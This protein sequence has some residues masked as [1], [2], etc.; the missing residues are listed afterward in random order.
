MLDT[1]GFVLV[2]AGAGS[3]KTRVL[4]YRIAHLINQ[5]VKPW[6][7]LAITFTNKA[8]GEMRHRVQQLTGTDE[9]LMCTFHSLC[10]RILRREAHNLPGYGA[11]FTIY[12]EAESARTVSAILKAMGVDEKG[13]KEQCLSAISAAKSAGIPP[14]QYR[15]YGHT[16]DKIVEVYTRYEAVLKASNAFD[17]DDLLLKTLQLLKGNKEVLEKYRQRYKYVHVDE[18]QDTN[19]VQY[20]IARLLSGGSGN[21]FVVGDDDQCIYTWR[22][23]D[24][25]GL[26]NFKKK[27]PDTKIYK[28]EQNFRSTQPI[29]KAANSVISNNFVRMGKELFTA[30][31][32]G[33]AVVFRQCADDRAEADYILNEI[34]SLAR[35]GNRPLSDF[36]ILVRV[37]SV[38]RILE[39]R[40]NLYSIP[41]RLFGGFRFY[42]RKEI[43]DILAYLRLAVNQQ[44]KDALLRIINFPR[45]G[46][47]ESS[48]EKLEEFAYMR[49]L[50]LFE[51]LFEIEEAAEIPN[52]ARQKFIAFR[53]F[54]MTLVKESKVRPLGDFVKYLIEAA[55]F[56]SAFDKTKDED[57]QKLLNI[58]EFV[59]SVLEFE[60]EFKQV[61]GVDGTDE[62]H[63]GAGVTEFLQSVSLISAQDGDDTD[64]VTLATVHSV[65][66]LEFP[67][68]FVAGLEEKIFPV[69]RAHDEIEDLEEERRIMY[70]AATRAKERLYL[71]CAAQR[72]RFG[73]YENNSISRFVN[74]AGLRAAAPSAAL[75]GRGFSTSNTTTSKFSK[76]STALDNRQPA[77]FTAGKAAVAANSANNN[78]ESPTKDLTNFIVGA[79]VEH[80]TYG[81]GE[82]V[83]RDGDNAKISFQGLGIKVFNLHLAP[84]QLRTRLDGLPNV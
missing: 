18:F 25:G 47:G 71:T 4:T 54:L 27:H 72:F 65:K 34:S 32:G 50:D 41:Y 38:T 84:I 68:V 7:I 10:A 3:G 44:D 36:A 21:L 37:S 73:R 45:R 9:V 56:E 2:L 39:E 46:I 51:A 83:E 29:L 8:A 30:Q 12:G 20:Q 66:G 58:D 70:V 81:A 55:N 14:G 31:D 26:L 49:S 1:Q 64:G 59:T 80:R 76:G 79:K 16:G 11:N 77:W 78:T 6:N 60:N 35:R 40:L 5:G 28:L 62:G 74:E 24:A 23:A 63:D 19:R 48:I 61:G 17:F 67:V 82:I 52:A 57:R 15:A 69:A 75:L 22:G 33:E 53:E 13:F 42:E 43:K